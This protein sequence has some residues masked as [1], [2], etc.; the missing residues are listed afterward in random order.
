MNDAAE[1]G[2]GPLAHVL[3]VEGCPIFSMELRLRLADMS[4]SICGVVDNA[5]DALVVARQTRPDVVIIGTLLQGHIN[6]VET[7][8][9][10]E[11]LEIPVV[12][13]ST[14]SDAKPAHSAATAAPHEF[15]RK[16]L[17]GDELER[18]VSTALQQS[19]PGH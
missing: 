3:I 1:A 16:P 5:I 18:M 17:Q 10:F 19:Y 12:H 7:A 11:T 14:R 2:A 13:V 6:G 9:L 15:V 8:R 4:C